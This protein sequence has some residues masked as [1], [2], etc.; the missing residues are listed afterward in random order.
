VVLVGLS[1]AGKSAVGPAVAA[2]LGWRFADV[3]DEIVRQSGM[4]VATLFRQHGE[5]DFRDMEAR[6]TAALCSLPEIV[7]APGAGWAARPGALDGLPADTAVVWLRVA[8]EEALRRLR[9]ATEE[10][11]L[12]AGPDPLSALTSMAERRTQHYEKA[13]LVIDVGGRSVDE[14]ARTIVEWLKR[15]TS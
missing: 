6:L 7:V 2:L 3:D 5:A 4:S 1:G 9:G 14:I 10:R 15:S 12:L 13:D 8:P 11:P